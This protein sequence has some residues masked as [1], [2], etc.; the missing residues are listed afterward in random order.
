LQRRP[1][2]QQA[3]QVA[4]GTF[5]RCCETYQLLRL[6][7]EIGCLV[8]QDARVK[9]HLVAALFAE[10][11]QQGLTLDEVEGATGP[12]WTGRIRDKPPL[13]TL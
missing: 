11:L 4:T 7:R 6:R 10:I 13:R 5:L 9:R 1:P 8:V 2:A 3:E 12:K